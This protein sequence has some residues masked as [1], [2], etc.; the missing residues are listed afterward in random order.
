MDAV[1]L[2]HAFVTFS[3]RE[4]VSLSLLEVGEE[5]EVKEVEIAGI[6]QQSLSQ[7]TLRL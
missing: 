3:S 2:H 1:G 6:G 4:L 7:K 5:L